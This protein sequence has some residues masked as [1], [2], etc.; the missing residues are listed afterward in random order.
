MNME[1]VKDVYIDL[2]FSAKCVLMEKSKL[3]VSGIE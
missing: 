3:K 2:I 1:L